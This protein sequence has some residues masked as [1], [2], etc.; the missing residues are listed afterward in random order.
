MLLKEA[1]M[2]LR[3]EC[4]TSKNKTQTQV[5]GGKNDLLQ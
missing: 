1:Q 3:E 2:V 4:L 5:V